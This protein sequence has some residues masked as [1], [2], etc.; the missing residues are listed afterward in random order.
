MIPKKFKAIDAEKVAKSMF[1]FASMD[2]LGT[3]IHES[4]ELQDF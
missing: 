3:F 4:L 1:H 2:Q